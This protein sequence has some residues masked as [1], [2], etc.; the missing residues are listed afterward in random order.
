MNL[1]V[2]IERSFHPF[3]CAFSRSWLY[4]AAI[5]ITTCAGSTIGCISLLECPA[6]YLQVMTDYMNSFIHS[7]RERIWG[8]RFHPHPN[9]SVPVTKALRYINYYTLKM[10]NWK[11]QNPSPEYFSGNVPDSRHLHITPSRSQLPAQTS[12][13]PPLWFYL[14]VLYTN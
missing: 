8:F 3:L 7:T 10:E 1:V 2:T 4:S 11:P 12:S 5:R 13:L 14:T 9:K 6:R